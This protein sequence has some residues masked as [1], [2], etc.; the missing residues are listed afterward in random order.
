M[1]SYCVKRRKESFVC[2]L[3]VAMP[4]LDYQNY[5]CLKQTKF[6]N[7]PS[8]YY[9][10]SI[11]LQTLPQGVTPGNVSISSKHVISNFDDGYRVIFPITPAVKVIGTPAVSGGAVT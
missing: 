5:H 6:S 1:G 2:V 9:N 7:F 10:G 4:S 8:L 3:E 11:K